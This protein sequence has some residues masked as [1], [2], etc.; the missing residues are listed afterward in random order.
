M[1]DITIIIAFIAGLVSFLSPCVLPLIPGFLAY[2]AGSSIHKVQAKRKD[3][4]LN[5]LFF[6]LGFSAI[7][8]ILGVLLNTLLET[9]AYD[10]SIW[11]SRIGGVII[12]FFGLYLTGLIK[13][14]F[15]EKEHKFKVKTKGRSKY[16]TSFLFGSAF[17][18]GWTPC[19]GAAL[20]AILGL[21]ATSP[22][23]AF[24]LLFSYSLGL[25]IPFLIVG[26]FTAQ[27]S[28]AIGRFSHILKYINIVFGIILIALGVLVFTQSLNLIANL[29]LLNRWLLR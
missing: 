13:I 11:L 6:V 9:I 21:A 8:A 12:I 23:L 29:D 24:N 15:L 4:F 19:V 28:S 5:S 3:I 25:G 22:G 2:L 17:A 7:F 14:P 18:A 20:G 10:V 16:L 1:T 27:A 26:L